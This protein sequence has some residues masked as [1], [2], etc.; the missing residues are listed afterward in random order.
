MVVLAANGT[1][2]AQPVR[3]QR[4]ESAFVAC[5]GVPDAMLMDHGTPWLEPAVA[6]GQNQAIVVLLMRQ[7]IRIVLERE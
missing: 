2:D 7:G 6:L 4:W 3:E 1:I 5:G